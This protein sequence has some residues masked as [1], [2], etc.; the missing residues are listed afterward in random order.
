MKPNELRIGN[1]VA[2]A[3]SIWK[4]SGILPPHPVKDFYT[5]ELFDNGVV[6]A[7]LEDLQPIPLTAE[8]VKRFGLNQS[9]LVGGIYTDG[10]LYITVDMP[11]YVHQLQ[12][13]YFALTGEELTIKTN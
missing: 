2:Y 4:V 5:V 6:D 7:K 8:W 9:N 1:Y 12:N 3:G 10:D 11:K 13:L